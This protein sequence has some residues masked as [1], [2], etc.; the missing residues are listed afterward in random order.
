MLYTLIHQ[1]NVLLL[2]E[3]TND[4]DLQ[5]LAVVEEFLDH[6]QG[7]LI[8]VSHDRYF[9]DR[10]VDF[11]VSFEE[12]RVSSRYPAPFSVYQQLRADQQKVGQSPN[13]PITPKREE[14]STSPKLTWKEQRELEGLE[15]QIEAL[16]AQKAILQVEINSSGSDYVRLQALAEQ[17]QTLEA[18]LETTLARWFE[19][20]ELAGEKR[21]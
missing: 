1:P 20:S 2:D 9:L 13:T 3:P 6:F 21:A 11:L 17:L 8:V 10:T 19:L 14:K 15:R 7:S 16:E 4:L 5:T 12:G 18:D